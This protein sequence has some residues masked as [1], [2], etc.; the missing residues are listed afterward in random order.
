MEVG[1]E[2]GKERRKEVTVS[3]WLKL[4]ETIVQDAFL[5]MLRV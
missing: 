2:R 1:K 3:C 5:K 4:G